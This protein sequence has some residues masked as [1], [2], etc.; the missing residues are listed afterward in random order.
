MHE[1]AVELHL[2]GI[3]G[4]KEANPT[5]TGADPHGC[6][7]VDRISIRYGICN[8]T[9]EIRRDSIIAIFHHF[10]KDPPEQYMIPD[11]SVPMRGSN[12]LA[13]L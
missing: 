6:S 5:Y 2:G 9:C 13:C 4:S 7:R 3:T 1:S 11:A 12:E 10:Y 8:W